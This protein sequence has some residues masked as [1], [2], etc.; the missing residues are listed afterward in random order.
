MGLYRR[1]VEVRICGS[2]VALPKFISELIR[3]K[4]GSK[5]TKFVPLHFSTSVIFS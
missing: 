4:G 3:A 2:E 5:N 1:T